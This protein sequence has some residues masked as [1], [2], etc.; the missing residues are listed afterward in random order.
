MI[1][2]GDGGFGLVE[3][4]IF[5]Q[6]ILTALPEKARHGRVEWIQPIVRGTSTL[7]HPPA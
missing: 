7:S 6:R 3:F 2:G 1:V 5:N 4:F